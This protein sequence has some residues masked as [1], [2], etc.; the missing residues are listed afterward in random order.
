MTDT[1]DVN[2]TQEKPSSANR[3]HTST[4]MTALLTLAVTFIAVY[5][6]LSKGE[7]ETGII[8]GILVF[9]LVALIFFSFR[10]ADYENAFQVFI[11]LPVGI[12]LFGV[13]F[14]QLEY[15]SL[16]KGG[17]VVDFS[18]AWEAWFLLGAA[19][20]VTAVAMF[21]TTSVYSRSKN[22]GRDG[23]WKK[24]KESARKVV[25]EQ[26]GAALLSFFA[27]FL[28]VTFLLGMS[29]AIADKFGVHGDVVLIDVSKKIDMPEK[30]L[31][32]CDNPKDMDK[33]AMLF[34]TGSS[35]PLVKLSENDRYPNLPYG[36]GEG[37]GFIGFDDDQNRVYI[38]EN[39][40]ELVDVVWK[41]EPCDMVFSMEVFPNFKSGEVDGGDIFNLAMAEKRRV[42]IEKELHKIINGRSESSGGSWRPRP[43]INL[44]TSE[45]R[46]DKYPNWHTEFFG[47]QGNE[48]D[49]ELVLRDKKTPSNEKHAAVLLTP[50]S[51]VVSA[52][53]MGYKPEDKND[54]EP[55]MNS[56][57]N[58]KSKSTRSQKSQKKFIDYLYFM[59]YTITT[60]GYGDLHPKGD[61]ARLLVSIANLIEV[62][63]G[64]I[65]I[66]VLIAHG[67]LRYHGQFQ[68]EDKKTLPKIKED[69]SKLA[70]EGVRSDNE[71]NRSRETS[72][73]VTEQPNPNKT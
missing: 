30:V 24:F 2:E 45:N 16:E 9:L 33:Y 44:P 69:T 1:S 31:P 29:L 25:T 56:G 55:T 72:A 15:N 51:M 32:R 7:L 53:R 60:T 17:N 27:Q 65:F 11:N 71:A 8:I 20:V 63:F 47:K 48:K 64:V 38:L 35:T 54:E 3:W 61:F 28:T 26:N 36:K 68:Q 10:K 41:Q 49:F 67:M 52:N 4:V 34:E 73:R 46:R 18:P 21:I 39:I 70:N 13:I 5:L 57:T 40:N 58:V 62:F 37:M 43:R 50:I 23:L 19:L 66:N 22:S 6:I 42:A 12:F 59:I 14:F